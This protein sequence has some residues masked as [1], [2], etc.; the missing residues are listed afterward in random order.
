MAMDSK[1]EEDLSLEAK[2]VLALSQAPEARPFR[3][4]PT[5][6]PTGSL[7]AVHYGNIYGGRSANTRCAC[8]PRLE[9]PFGTPPSMMGTKRQNTNRRV[10]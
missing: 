10:S 5:G 9:L 2:G 7:Q 8:L 1:E 4:G 6:P 3:E